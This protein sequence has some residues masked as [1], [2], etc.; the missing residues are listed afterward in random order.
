MSVTCAAG[1]ICCYFLIVRDATPLIPLQICPGVYIRQVGVPI[2]VP[3]SLPS[4]TAFFGRVR[5]S[6]SLVVFVFLPDKLAGLALPRTP[7]A[8]LRLQ[9]SQSPLF[10]VCSSDAI[11]LRFS[12]LV[13]IKHAVIWQPMTFLEAPFLLPPGGERY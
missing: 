13:L 6:P 12:L 7:I 2:S 1:L 11:T 10:P 8:R 3:P 9:L 5:L 4:A